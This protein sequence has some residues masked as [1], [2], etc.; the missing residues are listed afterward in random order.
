MARAKTVFVVSRLNWRPNGDGSWALAP[1]T[2]RLASFGTR[3]EAEI[4]SARR[5]TNARG[6]VNPFRCGK[7]FEQLT[8][9]PEL[10]FLDWVSDTGLSPPKA[11]KG[12]ARDW[13]AWWDATKPDMTTEQHAKL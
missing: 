11:K 4:E 7:P 6:R 1:D 9:L 10:I 12:A 3:D 8:A 5:E 13:A 2:F